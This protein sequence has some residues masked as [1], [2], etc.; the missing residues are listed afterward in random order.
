VG[1]REV[2]DLI[3]AELLAASDLFD[4]VWYRAAHPEA[5][6]PISHY[7]RVGAAAG[8]DPSPRFSTKEYLAL[9]R[10]VADA[11]CNPLVHYLRYGRTEGR[12]PRLAWPDPKLTS[13]LDH[14]SGRWSGSAQLTFRTMVQLQEPKI[15]YHQRAF[16]TEFR[17]FDGSQVPERDPRFN[18]C[19][20]FTTGALYTTNGDIIALSERGGGLHGG[21]QVAGVDLPTVP[22]PS[23]WLEKQIFEGRTLYLGH[24]MNQYGHFITETLSRFWAL[25]EGH[26]F[27]RY[28]FFPFWFD[29]GKPIFAEAQDFFL[30]QFAI[31]REKVVFL[32]SPVLFEEIV[33]PE[34]LFTIADVVNVKLSYIYE[35]VRRR[36]EQPSGVARIFLSRLEPYARIANVGAVED[37]FRRNGFEIVYP[38]RLPIRQQMILYANCHVMAGFAGSSLHNSLFARE[39]TLVIELGDVRSRGLP[40]P[41]QTAVNQATSV[42]GVFLPYMGDDEGHLNIANLEQALVHLSLDRLPYHSDYDTQ[43]LGGQQADHFPWPGTFSAHISNL[44]DLRVSRHFFIDGGNRPMEGFVVSLDPNSYVGV[45]YRVLEKGGTWSSWLRSGSFAGSRGQARP[46]VGFSARVSGKG[47]EEFYCVNIGKF[48]NSDRLIWSLEGESCQAGDGA[49]LTSVEIR[50][51]R[52]PRSPTT[53]RH[54]LLGFESLLHSGLIDPRRSDP[55]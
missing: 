19:L 36:F 28:A 12:V 33:V 1:F 2:Q 4:P 6:D 16:S 7:L 32:T 27:D 23:S 21:D 53:D 29:G 11:G 45:E 39:G 8:F 48:L 9:Y 55:P 43:L 26:D 47:V 44:G 49:A 46:L 13:Q 31:P 20:A 54:R 14:S 52:R 42:D 38:E 3:D 24:F 34:R 37:V 51:H 15:E 40:L 41:Q 25:R 50:L 35:K 30:D 10:D 18:H 5:V 22:P 17:I